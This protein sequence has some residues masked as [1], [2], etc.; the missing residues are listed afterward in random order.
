[1]NGVSNGLPPVLD[2]LGG[3]TVEGLTPGLRGEHERG[4]RSRQPQLTRKHA[5]AAAAT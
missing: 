1:M 2:R 3:G 4:M 5:T